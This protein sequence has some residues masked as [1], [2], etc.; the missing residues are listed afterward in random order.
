MKTSFY[1]NFDIRRGVPSDGIHVQKLP[2]PKE[3]LD[4]AGIVYGK[5]LVDFDKQRGKYRP[6]F[7]G[8]IIEKNFREKVVA[9]RE[10]TAAIQK[11][12]ERCK[13]RA[14]KAAATR[15][16]KKVLES[17]VLGKLASALE[18]A[19]R[20]SDSAKSRA[21]N[22]LPIREYYDGSPYCSA[23]Y[24]RSRGARENDYQAKELAVR[25][26]CALAPL[27]GIRFGWKREEG[28]DPPWVVYFD[29]PTGQVSF[30]SP[31]RGEGPE[32]PEEW[33]GRRASTRR[34]K[35]LIGRLVEQD[36]ARVR[37]HNLKQESKA[38]MG[39]AESENSSESSNR[40]MLLIER[41]TCLD[42]GSRRV[43]ALVAI[44]RSREAH[45]TYETYPNPWAN[46]DGYDD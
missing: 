7:D 26:A 13:G 21:A 6:V 12:E 24:R 28:V 30:H 44:K 15:Q 25:D 8:F 20:F 17:T 41:K 27:A 46:Q 37:N 2:E 23:N 9:S 40:W 14:A 18:R 42:A 1:G 10:A 4:A 11:M 32:Y 38:M 5:A 22:G 3:V 43:I 29:L 16:R 45:P 36:A 35:E 33:D 39:S 31:V 34:I 19:Q